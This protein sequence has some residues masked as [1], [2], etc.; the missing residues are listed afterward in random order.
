MIHFSS[1]VNKALTISLPCGGFFTDAKL[2]QY[3]CQTNGFTRKTFRTPA[4]ERVIEDFR[5]WVYIANQKSTASDGPGAFLY[6]NLNTGRTV[7]YVASYNSGGDSTS[8]LFWDIA[9]HELD[10]QL[11]TTGSYDPVGYGATRSHVS[12]RE[13]G[14]LIS[15]HEYLMKIRMALDQQ[16]PV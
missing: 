10:H 9:N 2:V 15:E 16:P 1:Q 8:N 11:N 3:F 13:V 7:V 4:E 6:C 14:K 5:S 12:G